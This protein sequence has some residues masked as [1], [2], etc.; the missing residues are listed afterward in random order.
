YQPTVSL[1]TVLESLKT[2]P[3]MKIR[4]WKDV[5]LLDLRPK[6]GTIKARN[7]DELEVQVD[8]KTGAILSVR[9]R[10]NDIV[11]RMHDG[12]AWGL[13]LLIFLPVAMVAILI[14][15][16]GLYLQVQITVNKFRHRDRRR[17]SV[18]EI[19]AGEVKPKARRRFN[20]IVFCRKY[21]YVLG[22]VVIIP[23]LIVA[24]SGLLLQVRYEVPWVMP[25]LQKGSEGAPTF[26]FE[27]ILRKAKLIPNIGISDWRDV[28]RLYVYP[29][30]GIVSIRT[31]KRWQV[32][33][34]AQ[35][36]ELLD[37]SRRRTDLIE[38]VHEG[39]WMGANLWLFLPV[40]ILS[41]FLWGFGI[42]LAFERKI[43]ATQA[44][45]K[46]VKLL[47]ERKIYKKSA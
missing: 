40:H 43:P 32:Q 30:E 29:N 39:K 46:T 12:G 17:G 4:S 41:V 25:Q 42:I 33:F 10:W 2:V 16:S 47:S 19:I 31:K 24:S 28:W 26:Q 8:A 20:L 34:D 6:Q 21:H 35:T 3:E 45:S 1:N 38:D 22:F 36:G 7:Y 5:K 14:A 37:L 44:V 18:S 15:M 9:Q 13:R 23:W 27:N 11:M